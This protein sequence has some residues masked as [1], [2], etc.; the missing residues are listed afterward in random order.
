MS[1]LSDFSRDVFDC[2]IKR[3]GLPSFRCERVYCQAIPANA[4]SIDCCK[5][6]STALYT[7]THRWA[8]F[9]K[10]DRIEEFD[11]T[12]C[13]GFFLVTDLRAPLD[14]RSWEGVSLVPK[15]RG[16]ITI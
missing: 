6:Y 3:D 11:G 5:Q 8:Q 15:G 12:L 16:P 10:L 9:F 14:D 4:R 7:A 2:L 1:L 13:D